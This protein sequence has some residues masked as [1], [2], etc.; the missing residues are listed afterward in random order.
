M[1]NTTSQVSFGSVKSLVQPCNEMNSVPSPIDSWVETRLSVIWPSLIV[2]KEL[3]MIQASI[4]DILNWLS[5]PPAL[6]DQEKTNLYS[7]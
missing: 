6:F 1:I 2:D 3:Q 5:A 4:S 7:Q